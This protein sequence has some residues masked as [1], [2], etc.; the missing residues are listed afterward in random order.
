M[1]RSLPPVI[2]PLSVLYC[3]LSW[4]NTSTTFPVSFS[5]MTRN[6]L[7]GQSYSVYLSRSDLLTTGPRSPIASL[8]SSPARMPPA[9]CPATTAPLLWAATGNPKSA[10]HVTTTAIP[11]S[12]VLT[13]LLNRTLDDAPQNRTRRKENL[14]LQPA[15]I[16]AVYRC[17]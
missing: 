11:R 16:T 3:S 17:G 1:V 10:M 8:I 14:P 2:P 12:T 7:N 15:R 4:I 6:G 13:V 9:D 5:T